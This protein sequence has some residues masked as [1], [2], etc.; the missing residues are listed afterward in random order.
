[1]TATRQVPHAWLGAEGQLPNSPEDVKP[2]YRLTEAGWAQLRR[3]HEW[4]IA[5]FLVS[6]VGTFAGLVAL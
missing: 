5:T 4:L 2:I 1:M 3:T 6:L